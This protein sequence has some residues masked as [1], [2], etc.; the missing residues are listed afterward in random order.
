MFRIDH[1]EARAGAEMPIKRYQ[2]IQGTNH[3]SLDQCD[4]GKD[5]KR[6][7]YSEYMLTGIPIGFADGCT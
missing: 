2:K 5:G 6:W 7:S 1:N 3:G 4:R